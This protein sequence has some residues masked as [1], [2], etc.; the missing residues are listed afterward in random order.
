M[1]VLATTLALDSKPLHS[2][3]LLLYFPIRSIQYFNYMHI[4]LAVSVNAEIGSLLVCEPAN[5]KYFP[6]ALQH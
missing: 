2:S 5:E 4:V 6:T 3:Y 1:Q